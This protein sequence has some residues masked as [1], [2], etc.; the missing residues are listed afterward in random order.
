MFYKCVKQYDSKDCAAACITSLIKYFGGRLTLPQVLS[1]TNMSNAGTNILELIRTCEQVG[2]N[3]VAMKKEG[4]QFDAECV[5]YPCI[6]HVTLKNGMNHFVILYKV[7]KSEVIVADPALGI[8]RVKRNDFFNHIVSEKSQYYWSGILIFVKPTKDFYSMGKPE[9]KKSIIFRA[10]IS[11]KKEIR[12]IIIFSIF[13]MILQIS[14]PFFFQVV[15]DE[16]IPQRRFYTLIF[17]TLTFLAL[18]FGSIYLS[19]KCV[20]NSL[21]LSREFNCKVSVEYYKHILN[22]PIHFHNKRKSGEIISRFQDIAKIQESLVTSIL[23]LPADLLMIAVVSGLLLSKSVMIFVSVIIICLLYLVIVSLFRNEYELGNAKQ[24]LEGSEVTTCFV[25]S[26]EGIETIKTNT[27]ED[28]CYKRTGSCF[29]KWQD[30]IL[31]LGRLENFQ[32]FLKSI[33]NQ[34]GELILIFISS[35]EVINGN[36]SIGEMVTYNLLI[37]YLLKPIRNVIDL[38]PQFQAAIVAMGRLESILQIG[39]ETIGGHVLGDVSSIELNNISFA[40]DESDGVISNVS[41]KEDLFKKI[42][43]VGKSGSG[44]TTLAK[45]LLKLYTVQNGSVLINGKNISEINVNNLRNKIIYVSQEDYIFSASI[46]DNFTLWNDSIPMKNIVK[47]A[48]L[49]QINDYVNSLDHQFDTLLEERGVNLSK[50]QKQKIAIGRAL[51]RKP[52]IL[53]LDEAT[54]NMDSDSEEKIYSEIS[55]MVDLKLIVITHKLTNVIDSDQ[56]YV[57]NGGK[58]VGGGKHNDLIN[59]NKYY[60]KLF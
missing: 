27:L 8:H 14:T 51:L 38:Q 20:D 50:G 57:M 40:Y 55:R 23:V 48:K 37:N 32:F 59:T 3:A 19:K 22:L 13:S 31:I 41:L 4:E 36:M 56:I 54:S 49:V 58:V 29:R 25:E 42:A 1:Y 16:I 28:C 18:T 17:A 15:V 39:E 11:R 44:K 9:T 47:I 30:S 34:F 26:L 21:I 12:K 45:I 43:I 60:K 46:K 6:A 7:T 35:I 2:L 52:Q 33:I 24:M 5:D 53:I 10:F